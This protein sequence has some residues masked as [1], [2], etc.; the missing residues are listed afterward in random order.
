VLH[1][2]FDVLVL[3]PSGEAIL[4]FYDFLTNYHL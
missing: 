1:Q 3:N 4:P 2:I